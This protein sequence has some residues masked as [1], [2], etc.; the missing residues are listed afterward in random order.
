M[1]VDSDRH[2]TLFATARLQCGVV[3]R[4]QLR[5]HG[6]SPAYVSQQVAAHRWRPVGSHV[7]VLHNTDL[8]RRQLMGAAVLDA[9]GVVA[10]GSHTALELAGFRAVGS[11]AVEIHLVVPRG[12]RVTPI[13][14]VRVHES[15]RLDPGWLQTAHGL[16]VTEVARSAIDA[17]AW[18][19]WPRFACLMMAAVVQQRLCS[20]TDL[21]EALGRVGRV[22]HKHYLRL[23]VADVAG[24]SESLGEIDLL[25]LCRQH[26]LQVPRRQSSRRDRSG[27]TRYLD[28]EWLLPDGSVLVLEIDGRHHMDA[29]SWQDDLRRERTIALSGARVLRAT[30]FEVRL[31]PSLIV[32]DLRAAGVPS[33]AD[34]SGTQTAIAS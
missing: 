2:P 13:D 6:V 3:S 14:G 21:E 25:R 17:A 26:R 7:M 18:Q 19:P 5:H 4:D 28:C 29:R 23:A 30:A 16:P 20:A 33:T 15:R 27:R 22:R 34:L 8:T 31:E 32:A 1:Y 24:G 10:L 9:P 11:E 12:D